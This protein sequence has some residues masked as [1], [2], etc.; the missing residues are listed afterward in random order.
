MNETAAASANRL[1]AALE[2]ANSFM[3]F[4]LFAQPFAALFPHVMRVTTS[5]DFAR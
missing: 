4:V 1:A 3:Q 2:S 5:G